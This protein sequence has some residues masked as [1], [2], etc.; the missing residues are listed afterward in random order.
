MVKGSVSHEAGS[1][2]CDLR[3][4]MS[5]KRQAISDEPL[6][7]YAASCVGVVRWRGWRLPCLDYEAWQRGHDV[8]FVL[9]NEGDLM[10]IPLGLN[11]QLAAPHLPLEGS[12]VESALRGV[13]EWIDRGWQ[14][15]GRMYTS[16][17]GYEAEDDFWRETR[18]SLGAPLKAPRATRPARTAQKRRTR[19]KQP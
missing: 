7:N 13:Q 15:V 18:L 8:V 3:Y 19:T 6:A 12:E 9:E 17:I 11:G 2:I 1:T 4:A 10:L 5:N 16:F 14:V